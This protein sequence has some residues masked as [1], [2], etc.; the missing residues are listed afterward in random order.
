MQESKSVAVLV[1]KSMQLRGLD[2][3]PP[4]GICSHKKHETWWKKSLFTTQ[5]LT[6]CYTIEE[7]E[8]QL[9]TEI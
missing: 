4:R 8:S 5:K 1:A 3:S 9:L 2:S 6:C 7:I